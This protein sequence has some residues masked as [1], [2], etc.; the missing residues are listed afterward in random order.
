VKRRTLMV[1]AAAAIASTAVLA[2]D[3]GPTAPNSALLP[4]AGHLGMADVVQLENATQALRALDYRCGGGACRDAIATQLMAAQPLLGASGTDTV[5][6]RLF[7]ALSDLHNLAGWTAFDA[8]SLPGARRHFTTA[9]DY[10]HQAGDASLLSNIMY[11]IG[12]VYVHHGQPQPAL[13]WFDRGLIYAQDCRSPLAA[14][15][16]YANQA[17]ADAMMGHAAPA[18][19]LLGR[20]EEQL[21]KANLAE[22]PDWARFY[23]HTDLYAM[24]G[25]V[26][27]ELSVFDPRHAPT[28]IRALSQALAGYDDSMH[29]SQAFTLTMLATSHLRHGDIDH[30]VAVGHQALALA[31]EVTSQRVSDRMTPLQIQARRQSTHADSRELSDLIDQHQHFR[32]RGTPTLRNPGINVA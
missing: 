12:R 9:L 8:G 4:V 11:R 31:R 18:T 19:M 20:S 3:R 25:T 10:A 5:R 28:A 24:I 30:G 7:R 26:H 2:A 21:A 22:A 23:D 6:R 16:L 27:T 17:W 14:A 1:H 13:Q 15:V 29:R 32:S